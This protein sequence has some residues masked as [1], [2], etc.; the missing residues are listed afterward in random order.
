[1]ETTTTASAKFKELA[2]DSVLPKQVENRMTDDVE[3]QE[4]AGRLTEDEFAEHFERLFLKALAEQMAANE[5]LAGWL[6]TDE[7]LRWA[8][9]LVQSKLAAKNA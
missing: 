9:E 6:V 3:V 4:L 8:W 1:M 2:G 7:G 5:R